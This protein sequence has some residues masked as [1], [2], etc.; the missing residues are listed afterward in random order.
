MRRRMVLTAGLAMSAGAMSAGAARENGAGPVVLELFTSQGCSSCPPADALL[1]QLATRAEVIALAWHVDY[2]NR[3]GWPDP[4][5]S[6]A[7]TQRQ[8]L[9]AAQLHEDV[10]TP[11][12]VVNGAAM[13]VGSSIGAVTAAIRQAVPPAAAVTLGLAGDAVVVAV[14]PG[15]DAA[16]AVLVTYDAERMTAVRAGENGGRKLRE[17]RVVRAARPLDLSAGRVVVAGAA[18]GPGQ[19]VAVIVQ[20]RAWRVIGAAD[21]RPADRFSVMWPAVMWPAVA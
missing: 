1:G 12:M 8:R 5:A 6:P 18:P 21:L 13:V 3:L 10:Y 9:Y 15:L 2:W 16:M 20:D 4:F 14:M 7:W 11:A 17:F 19:G